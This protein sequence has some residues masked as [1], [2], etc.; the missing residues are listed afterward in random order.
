MREA[1]MPDSNAEVAETGAFGDRIGGAGKDAAGPAV[2]TQHD[3]RPSKGPS[4]VDYGGDTADT[5]GPLDR[6]TPGDE[7]LSVRFGT[8]A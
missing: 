8:E 2:T 5:P 1:R 7:P 3:D 6:P 4:A